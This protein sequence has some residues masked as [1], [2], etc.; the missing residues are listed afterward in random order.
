MVVY[1]CPVV[2]GGDFNLWAQDDNDRDTR[3]FA[4]LLPSFDMVQHVRGPTHLRGNTLDLVMTFTDRVP[5]DTTA[6]PPGAIS[7]HS[8]ITCH[9]PIQVD[10]PPLTERLVRGWRR[11]SRDRLHRALADRQLCST[12]PDD[13]DVD[14]LFDAYNTI[15]GNIVDQLAPVHAIRHRP[16]RPTP[17]FDAECRSMRRECRRLE[18][19]Y[20]RTQRPADRRLWVEADVAL[21]CIGRRRNSTGPIDWCSAA[22][23]HRASGVLCHR[24]RDVTGS[25][26]H[27]ADG[28]ATFFEKKIDD[29]RSDNA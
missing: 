24:Q 26:S 6:M 23:R 10:S 7:D 11:V 21:K 1:S 25:T 22:A 19:C 8:L 5:D 9:L 2:V 28:F 13:A 4:S 27:S 3:R 18:R 14:Q 12:V 20:R 29:I 16:G 15:L 17:W